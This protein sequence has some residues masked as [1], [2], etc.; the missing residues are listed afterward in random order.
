MRKVLATLILLFA[1]S[2]PGDSEAASITGN[3]FINLSPQ[4]KGWYFLGVLDS[5]KQTRD[6]FL[7]T[8]DLDAAKFDRLWETCISG[9]PVRQHLAILDAWLENNP[10]RWHEPAIE[11][12]F[13]AERDSCEQLATGSISDK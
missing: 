6:R 7:A 12:I 11:L 4:E 5:M 9:R 2:Q 1:L 13:V 10:N 3:D 8:S